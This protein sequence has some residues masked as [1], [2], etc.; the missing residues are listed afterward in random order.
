MLLS[1]YYCGGLL[2]WLKGKFYSLWAETKPIQY[3]I[4]YN[5]A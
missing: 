4:T 5:R 2:N 3:D 1:Q